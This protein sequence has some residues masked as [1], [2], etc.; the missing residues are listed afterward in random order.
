MKTNEKEFKKL[1]DDLIRAFDR[2]EWMNLEQQG[3]LLS[4]AKAWAMSIIYF[5]IENNLRFH[6]HP[7][8]KL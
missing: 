3:S 6:K 4:H 2:E 5:R 8:F 1:S 7:N